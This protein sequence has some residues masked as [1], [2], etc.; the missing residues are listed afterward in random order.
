[1]ILLALLLA[2]QPIAIKA[3]RMFDARKGAVTSP[4]LVVTE[5]DR[6]VQVGGQPPAGAQ[7]V[8]LG[9]ATLMPGLMDAHTH[10]TFEAGKSWYRDSMEGLLRWPAEQAQYAGEYARRTLDAGF[11]TVR[12]LGSSDFLDLGL[13]NAIDAGAIPGPRM[14]VAI[15]AIGA[16][17]GHADI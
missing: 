3:A 2:A 7:V 5:N 15:Y 1:M 13:R 16:R 17:G 8:D 14:F 4:G 12:D 9:D 11:T 10:V 6:I